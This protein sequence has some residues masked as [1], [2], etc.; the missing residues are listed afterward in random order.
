MP[1]VQ[2]IG[3]GTADNR[4]LIFERAKEVYQIKQIINDEK[5]EKGNLTTFERTTLLRNVLRKI[6]NHQ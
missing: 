1:R 3:S 5:D 2:P 6:F 4:E